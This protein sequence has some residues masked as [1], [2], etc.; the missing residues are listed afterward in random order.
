MTATQAELGEGLA[1]LRSQYSDKEAE[2]ENLDMA[3]QLLKHDLNALDGERNQ[4]TMDI[5]EH[6]R[7]EEEKIKPIINRL[8]EH[9]E[10]LTVNI[11]DAESKTLKEQD[12][13]NNIDG[14]IKIRDENINKVNEENAELKKED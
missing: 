2:L 7:I 4:L 14:D 10:D 12:D 9:N 3:V 8:I 1:N 11:K 13:F 5:D 6:K